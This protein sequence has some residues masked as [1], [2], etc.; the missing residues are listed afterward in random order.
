MI[1]KKVLTLSEEEVLKLVEAG[2]LLGSIRDSKNDF[3]EI[4]DDVK[5]L[6]QAIN[7]VSNVCLE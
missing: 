5:Q 4:P 3:D 1:I 6:I 7:E 2:K